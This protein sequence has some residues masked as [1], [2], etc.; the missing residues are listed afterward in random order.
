MGKLTIDEQQRINARRQTMARALAVPAHR[1]GTE[2]DLWLRRIGPLARVIA[3]GIAVVAGEQVALPH[4]AWHFS[5]SA[6]SLLEC[7]MPA[8]R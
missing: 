1:H 4:L 8:I 3:L 6:S 2:R 5:L 7:L